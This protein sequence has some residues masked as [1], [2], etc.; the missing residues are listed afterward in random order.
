MKIS[1]NNTIILVYPIPEVGLDVPAILYSRILFNQKKIDLTDKNNWITTSYDIFKKRSTSTF[2]LLDSINGKNVHRVYPHKFFC[3]NLI[4][5]RCITHD[6]Q[7]IFYSDNNHPSL[8]GAEII[9]DLIIQEI[10]KLN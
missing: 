9:N 5:D 10:E 4:K 3:D 1:Q 2:A 6:E 7:D 8:K